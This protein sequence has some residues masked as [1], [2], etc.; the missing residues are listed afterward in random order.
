MF[1]TNKGN[2]SKIIKHLK[3]NNHNLEVKPHIY[4]NTVI[5]P[6]DSL[7]IKFFLFPTVLAKSN[8]MIPFI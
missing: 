5:I 3:E 1:P 4:Y 7:I 6:M 2:F 8:F